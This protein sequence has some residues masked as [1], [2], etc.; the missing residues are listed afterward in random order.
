M[1][2]V[3]MTTSSVLRPGSP[4][5]RS[6]LERVGEGASE[7]E[8]LKEAPFAAM[9]LLRDAGFG[10]LRVPE[11]D[12]GA[13]STFREFFETLI[14]LAAVDPNVAHAWRSH[15]WFV[16]ETLL[17]PDAARRARLVGQVV[18]GTM[19]GGAAGELATHVGEQR[20]DTTISSDGDG[21]YRIDGT[22]HYTTGALYADYIGVIA[23]L[24]D[25][26][27]AVAVVPTNREGVTVED[28][29]DGFGQQLTAS[30]T[31]RLD[32][33][34]VAGDELWIY[35]TP[36]GDE[37]PPRS[38]L[39][40][41]LHLY[42]TAVIAGTLRIVVSDA[43]ALILRRARTFTHAPSEVPATDPLLQQVVGELA[44][45]AFAAEATVLAAADALDAAE[46]A[47]KGK[48]SP[49]RDLAHAAALRTSQAKVVVDG[50]GLRSA[51]ALLDV[52]GASATRTVFNLDRHWRNIRTLASHNPTIYK[53]MAIG[54]YI[55][56]GVP[57]PLN[58]YF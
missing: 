38:I 32:R 27:P 12:G 28:D 26:R 13:G 7:R 15:F 37:P 41:F 53:S 44:S 47:I 48:A 34:R 14:A 42:L 43:A 9:A 31:T 55:V 30:G 33:V 17:L 21:D 25:G 24:T 57:L 6:V 18:A 1:N 20:F 40:P 51:T 39:P 49:G 11:A 2:A 46:L 58:G 4:E 52:G 56:N 54:D 16:E 50:L 36:E 10:A 23:S 45:N 3:R 29:W 35:P 19:F 8:S 22:K 5:L